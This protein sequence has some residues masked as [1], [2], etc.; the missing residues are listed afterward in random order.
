MSKKIVVIAGPTA[1]GKSELAFKLARNL[2]GEII[3]ADSIQIYKYLQIGAAKP[4]PKWMKEVPHHLYSILNPDE[5]FTVHNYMTMA[6]TQIDEILKRGKIPFVVGGTG[7]YIRVL[8]HGL[9]P[10]PKVNKK[11]RESLLQKEQ[12]NPGSLY[13]ELLVIDPETAEKLHPSDIVRISRA[14]EVW[15][16]TGEKISTLQR[17]HAFSDSPYDYLG[18]FLDPDREKLRETI[19]IRTEK[20][21]KSGLIE[22]V[23]NLLAM[24]YSGELKPLKSVG[25]KEVILFLTGEISNIDELKKK[26]FKATWEL[27]RRQKI[28]FK[29]ERGFVF[30]KPD[31]DTIKKKVVEFYDT[32]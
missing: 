15:Y 32:K 4:D 31:F 6:R 18:L 14:L 26:I 2:N 25:Y 13:K 20:M 12:S 10:Q 8:L 5:E 7:L 27:A 29:K 17:K 23:K 30:V 21:L 28:W 22:E 11:L 16:T 3:N 19:A 24:G 9:F 1:S